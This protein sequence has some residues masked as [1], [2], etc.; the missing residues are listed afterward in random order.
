MNGTEICVCTEVERGD[1]SGATA[2][3]EATKECYRCGRPF[4][5]V[6]VEDCTH[7][8]G[9]GHEPGYGPNHHCRTCWGRSKADSQVDHPRHYNSSPSGVEC[10]TVVEHMTFN[11]GSAVKYLWRAGLKGER[12]RATE[13]AI[14][15]LQKARWYCD[16]E[17]ERLKKEGTR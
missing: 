14:L 2:F 12:S 15:D 1:V 3:E 4:K 5:V 11:T 13:P 6:F 9:T 7:C 10:I 8:K 17:I 16:R